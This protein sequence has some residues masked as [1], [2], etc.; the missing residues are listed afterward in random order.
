MRVTQLLVHNVGKLKKLF[1]FTIRQAAVELSSRKNN[2]R[3]TEKCFEWVE[4]TS[5]APRKFTLGSRFGVFRFW[6]WKRERQILIRREESNKKP[7]RRLVG[8]VIL[9]LHYSNIP[10]RNL[11]DL[12]TSLF[13]M[14]LRNAGRV[15]LGVK[16]VGLKI[17]NALSWWYLMMQH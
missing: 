5:W 13:L 2:L 6:E 8:I 1:T 16:R 11:A 7:M 4:I 12:M 3:C 15:I 17:E 14:W 9:P 10:L